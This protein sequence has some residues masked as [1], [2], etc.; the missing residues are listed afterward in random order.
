M[1]LDTTSLM[2]YLYISNVLVIILWLMWRISSQTSSQTVVESKVFRL[3]LLKC[4][5]FLFQ[6]LP[7]SWELYF[8]IM[9]LLVP[10]CWQI[11]DLN[12]LHFVPVVTAVTR[13]TAK[14]LQRYT[15]NSSDANKLIQKV[16]CIKKWLLKCYVHLKGK[17]I[18]SK[19]GSPYTYIWCSLSVV[20]V[21]M[22]E[23]VWLQRLSRV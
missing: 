21:H 11:Q 14:V 2:L 22:Y 23:C 16:N 3:L 7:V 15:I 10:Y 1:H 9:M 20:S 5:K 18:Y 12:M 13:Q 17:L 8:Y 19:Q 4:V 6:L